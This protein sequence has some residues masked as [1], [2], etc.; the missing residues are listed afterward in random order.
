MCFAQS[1][2]TCEERLQIIRQGMPKC[3]AGDG[4]H[5]GERVLDAVPALADQQFLGFFGLSTLLFRAY[6]LQAESELTRDGDREIHLRVGKDV[7][8][9]VVGHELA[10]E[11]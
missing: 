11:F 7:R 1:M 9:L 8:S 10:D 6:A 3:L 4:L 5:N 2:Q